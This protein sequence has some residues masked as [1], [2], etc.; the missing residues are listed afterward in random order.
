MTASFNVL[1]FDKTQESEDDED[2]DDDE[3]NGWFK[4]A[5]DMDEDGDDEDTDDF[6]WSFFLRAFSLFCFLLKEI[7]I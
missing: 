4:L 2:V 1:P 7:K 6:L 5:D 3:E